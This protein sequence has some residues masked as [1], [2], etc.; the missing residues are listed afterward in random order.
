MVWFRLPEF[1]ERASGSVGACSVRHPSDEEVVDDAPLPLGPSGRL[2][3]PL[4]ARTTAA[5]ARTLRQPSMQR[6]PRPGV[7][8]RSDADVENLSVR[9]LKAAIRDHKATSKGIVDKK[10]LQA[11]VR[12]LRGHA[13]LREFGRVAKDPRKPLGDY[14][15]ARAPIA[16]SKYEKLMAFSPAEL[17]A[18][19]VRRLHNFVFVAHH[20][21]VEPAGSRRPVLAELGCARRPLLAEATRCLAHL[22]EQWEVAYWIAV[23]SVPRRHPDVL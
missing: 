9:Q 10:D 20:A 7:A 19:S 3:G 8:I 4:C 13:L 18:F 16:G 15:R 2:R 21:F 6:P 5:S 17:E 1:L 12:L 22:T 14:G 23:S 11:R